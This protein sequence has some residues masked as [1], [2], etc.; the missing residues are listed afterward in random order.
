MID[1]IAA[2]VAGDAPEMAEKK[3]ARKYRGD[4][5]PASD[6]ADD[7][8]G[9]IDNTP[10]QASET[11]QGSGED[12]QG[13]GDPGLRRHA[14]IK[15]LGEYLLRQV[16]H[17]KRQQADDADGEADGNLGEHKEDK[18]KEKYKCGQYFHD[19][20]MFLP[21]CRV[22][23]IFIGRMALTCLRILIARNTVNSPKEIGSTI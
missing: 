10:R 22:Y 14:R 4:A 11:H 5:E 9:E 13:N 23:F 16:V 19:P 6:V 8:I 15:P 17:D 3:C 7:C 1:P 18:N 2:A 12:E 20:A 21:A